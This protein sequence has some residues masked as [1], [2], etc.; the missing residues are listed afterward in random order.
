M[1]D[2]TIDYSV[3][4]TPRKDEP[5]HCYAHRTKDGRYFAVSLTQNGFTR[6]SVS[7]PFPTWE[8]L[9]AHM[10]TVY[11]NRVWHHVEPTSL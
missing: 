3:L 11:S 5:V 4:A 8:A 1:T 7:P 10:R 2:D 6:P 9:Q